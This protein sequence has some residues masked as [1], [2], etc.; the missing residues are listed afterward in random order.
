MTFNFKKIIPW[1][2]LAL[3][4][5]AFGGWLIYRFTAE[6]SLRLTAPEGREVWR[7]NDTFQI[8]W[9]SRNIS[10]VGIILIRGAAGQDVQWIAQDVSA[11]RGSFEWQI[12]VWEEPRKD[13]KIAIFEYPWKQGNLIDRSDD[14]FTILGPQFASCDSLSTVA[15]WPFIPSDF[16]DLRKVF[17]TSGTWS[18]NLERL[19]GADR[20]CQSEA[21]QKGLDGNWKAFL[22]DDTN[23]A[24]DRL[25]LQGIFVEAESAGLLPE[26]KTCHRLLGSNFN[27]F[28]KKLS[29][30][31]ALNRGKFDES[32]LQDLQ[33]VWL[34]RI[35]K[36]SLRECTAIFFEQFPPRQLER[37]YSFTTTCQN[38]TIGLETA[39]GY[40]PSPG[41]EVEF[42]AC[43]TPAG[44]RTS[45][46]GLACLA[47]GL[48]GQLLTTSLGNSCDTA[49]K[50]LCVQQ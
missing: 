44:V 21:A 17:I 40:P 46:V 1:A 28:F 10:R 30:P 16:P 41:Q 3:I 33:N 25:N 27:D 49:Q 7:A 37:N 23:F 29:D 36:E 19:E 34:G 5:A 18:G 26:N 13:Y 32:F 43:F 6:K 11:R 8:T 24:V 39:L 50:L 4:I 15:E 9:K 35:T 2:V 14:F 48:Q 42:P 22:G 47:S 12:F 20:I 45:A 31:L 38:W